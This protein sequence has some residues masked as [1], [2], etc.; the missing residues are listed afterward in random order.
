MR[1]IFAASPKLLAPA[2]APFALGDIL[3]K[4]V[5]FIAP[6]LVK[7]NCNGYSLDTFYPPA[8]MA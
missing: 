8:T 5:D 7:P 1:A 4:R 3:E 2:L 6:A